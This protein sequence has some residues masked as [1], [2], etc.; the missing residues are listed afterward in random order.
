MARS[1]ALK[2]ST[3]L[4]FYLWPRSDV[5]LERP[6]TTYSWFAPP[7]PLSSIC[8]PSC[9][10][11][12]LQNLEKYPLLPRNG[13]SVERSSGATWISGFSLFKHRVTLGGPIKIKKVPPFGSFDCAS[14][15]TSS[16]LFEIAFEE[17]HYWARWLKKKSTNKM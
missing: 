7:V 16:S 14:W 2:M 5:L 6:L 3:F 8:D 11:R 13:E 17:M 9:D 1:R 4:T 15:N 12:C 10:K